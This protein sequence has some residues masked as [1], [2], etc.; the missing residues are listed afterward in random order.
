[1]LRG[2]QTNLYKCFLPQ[3]WYI[4]SPEG[5]SGF[6]HPE[7]V[8]DDPKGGMFREAMY[9]QARVIIFSLPTS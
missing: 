4:G 2:I 9:T 8:Y 6:L 7:G 1:M 5:V 3:A